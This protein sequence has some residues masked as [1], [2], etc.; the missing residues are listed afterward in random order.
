[1]VQEVLV[2]PKKSFK[3]KPRLIN[4][5]VR[6]ASEDGEGS[7]LRKST[8]VVAQVEESRYT[9]AECQPPEVCA[10][11]G[12]PTNVEVGQPRHRSA[13]LLA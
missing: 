13:L 1:M 7:R 6:T 3:S 9:C 4:V 10:K 12:V 5:K 8:S 2:L 11:E